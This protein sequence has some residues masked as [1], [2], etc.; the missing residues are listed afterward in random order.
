ML[1]TSGQI[2]PKASHGQLTE[3]AFDNPQKLIIPFLHGTPCP[4]VIFCSTQENL[5]LVQSAIKIS[6][7]R[8][9]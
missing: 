9:V 1:D 5:R 6:K 4:Y 7:R 3:T 8:A 2:V